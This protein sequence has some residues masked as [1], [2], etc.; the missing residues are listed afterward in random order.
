MADL[1]QNWVNFRRDTGEIY[2]FAG[3]DTGPWVRNSDGDVSL[4]STAATITG[5]ATGNISLTSSTGTITLATAAQDLVLT[6]YTYVTMTATTQAAQIVSGKVDASGLS[7]GITLTT[8]GGAGIKILTSGSRGRFT[9][10]VVDDILIRNTGSGAALSIAALG[11]ALNLVSTTYTDIAASTDVQIRSVGGATKKILIGSTGET[12]YLGPQVLGTANPL[13][14]NTEPFRPD[15]GNVNGNVMTRVAGQWQGVTPSYISTT[16]TSAHILVGNVSNVATDVAVTG[17]VTISN[18]GVTAIGALKVTNAMLAGSIDLTTKVTGTLPVGNGGTGAAT[19]TTKALMVGNGTSP[20]VSIPVGTD[21]QV[22]TGLTGLAPAF[23]SITGDITFSAAAAVA[24]TKIQGVAVKSGLTTTD[25]FV[26]SYVAANSR[27]E[28]VSASAGGSSFADDVFFVTDNGDATKKL[29]F[30]VSGVT[31]ATTRTLTVP[32]LSG[33][34]ALLTGAQTLDNKTLTTQNDITFASGSRL[35]DA[36]GDLSIQG[37]SG[38]AITGGTGGQTTIQSSRAS[39]TAIRILASGLL[40]NVTIE[41][42]NSGLMTMRSNGGG[43]TISDSLNGTITLTA[44]TNGIIQLSTTTTKKLKLQNVVIEP[45]GGV[46]GQ[47]LRQ[48]NAGDIVMGDAG[49]AGLIQEWAGSGIPTGWLLC[50][51]SAVSRTTYADLFAVLI[52]TATITVTIATPA[53]ISWASH[54]FALNDPVLF[55]NSG[56]ALPTGITASTT[57]YVSELTSSGT[58]KI[59]AAPGGANINTSGTQSGTHTGKF[60]PWGVGDGS[61]TFNVP[62]ISEKRVAGTGTTGTANALAGTGG[63][64]THTHTNTLTVPNHV[65]TLNDNG[66][67][68]IFARAATSN[69]II[70]RRT[71]G[72]S[73][74]DT[75]TAAISGLATA[76]AGVVQSNASTLGGITDNPTTAPALGGSVTAATGPVDPFVTLKYLIKT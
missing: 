6:G 22:L 18:A 35:L 32:N 72:A 52:R 13:V 17:D 40:G 48:D 49:R 50:D 21:G 3:V 64:T 25:G 43:V 59:A 12:I 45:S 42:T 62:N 14:I 76:T 38:V 37:A 73:F 67:A 4:R 74:T 23:Q 15:V 9:V 70:F 2:R 10:D 31:T 57:Y 41:S 29:A 56:G 11:G 55:T 8:T 66:Y 46:T 16:L 61:T 53:V 68:N 24:V 47:V 20:I 34:I 51:G 71:T 54:G 27:L 30:E 36:P 75:H 65:H 5:A 28:L 7:Y 44:G 60:Q 63:A 69:Q 26:L 1:G 58:F 39:S 19:L 33:T